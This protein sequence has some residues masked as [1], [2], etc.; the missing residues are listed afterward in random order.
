MQV[1]LDSHR[2]ALAARIR[3]Y[4]LVDLARELVEIAREGL[5]RQNQ[6]NES[7]R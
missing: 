2:D 6:V 4:S 3:R 5:R 7:R 1:Y